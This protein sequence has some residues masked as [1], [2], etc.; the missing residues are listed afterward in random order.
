MEEYQRRHILGTQAEVIRD[1]DNSGR[2][3]ADG[4]VDDQLEELQREAG[5]G[6][7][8][9]AA[10]IEEASLLEVAETERRA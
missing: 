1:N 4:A 10:G 2:S 7:A 8:V 6:V 5:W 3:D 9:S